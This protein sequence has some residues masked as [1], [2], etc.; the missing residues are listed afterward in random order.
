MT[1]T[2]LSKTN[3]NRITKNFVNQ[4][5]SGNSVPNFIV[6][7]YQIA[8]WTWTYLKR[9]DTSKLSHLILNLLNEIPFDNKMSTIVW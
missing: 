3:R 7:V 6:L 5:K 1:N 2:L 9:V 4:F 8:I